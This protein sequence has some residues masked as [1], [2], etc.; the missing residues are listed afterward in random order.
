MAVVKIIGINFHRKAFNS[1][2][3][4][5][6][7]QDGQKFGFLEVKKGEVKGR[8]EIFGSLAELQQKEGGIQFQYRVKNPVL[9]IELDQ[10][11][12]SAWSSSCFR[13]DPETGIEVN[14][15]QLR[16]VRGNQPLKDWTDIRRKVYIFQGPSGLGKSFLGGIISKEGEL[17]VFETD[18]LP[19]GQGLPEVIAEDVIILGNRHGFSIE[20]VED[21]IADKDVTDVV[22][23]SFAL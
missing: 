11:F 5:V 4:K 23:V 7:F 16:P 21:R 1:F 22:K 14:F 12:T 9:E 15:S 10:A 13:F 8:A 2:S 3:V 20:E 19:K 6:Y 17:S 18:A